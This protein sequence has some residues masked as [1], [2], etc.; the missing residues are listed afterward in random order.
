M[1]GATAKSLMELSVM[2]VQYGIELKT[3]FLFNESLVTRARIYSAD[4]FMRSGYTHMMFIDSDIGFKASDVLSL[5]ALQSEE[6]E[7]DVITGAYPKKC[8][9]WEK[10]KAAVD[11]GYADKDPQNL[12]LFVGDYVFNPIVR[13]GETSIQLDRPVEISE[14][15]T[16]F[17]MIRRPT[18]EKFEA[19]YPNLT[20]RP[21]HV[22]TENFDGTREVFQY[23]QA[24]IDPESK[25]YLSEDYWFCKKIRD[26]GMKVWLC[27]WIELQHNGSYS[28]GGSLAALAA[29]G[30]SATADSNAPKI[31]PR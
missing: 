10:I 20:F 3:Y 30:A 5:L 15:G 25:R 24:E 22:R 16:G 8:M 27:P 11:Q 19:S 18:L 6:S 2:C 12:E 7:Y 21:D 13:E 4:E 9:A 31:R 14:A 17:M 26:V 29:I 1:F 28:F 23:F